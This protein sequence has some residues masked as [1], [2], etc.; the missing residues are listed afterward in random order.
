MPVPPSPIAALRAMASHPIAALREIASHSIAALRD[1]SPP[2]IAVSR[3]HVPSSNA[4][5]HEEVV[6][7]QRV[8]RTVLVLVLLATTAT[9]VPEARAQRVAK[10]GAD[11]LGVG[12]GGRALGM[13]GAYVAA[14]E[15]VTSAYWNPAGLTAMDSLEVAYMHAERFAGVVTFDYA[16]VGT[17]ISDRST[18]GVTVIRSGV[19]DIKNT[20][21]AW[22]PVRGAPR[23]NPSDHITTFSAADYAFM[24]SAGRR[25]G[26]GLAAGATAKIVRRSIGDF[27]S[28]WGYSVDVGARYQRGRW[29]LGASVRDVTTL[30]ESWSVDREATRPLED[31]FDLALPEGG[32]ELVLPVLRTGAA[33]TGSWR[34]FDGT[35]GLDLD[36]AFEGRRAYAFNAGDVSLHPRIGGELAYQNV[37]ALRGGLNRIY[38]AEGEG[39]VLS[40]TV[41]AGLTLGRV[42]V[43]Y[44]FGNFAGLAAEL[45]YSHR[46][47]LRIRLHPPAR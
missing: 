9:V 42:V 38:T 10:Y 21:Q 34:E 19:N 1:V 39:L 23:P 46:L 2:P 43:D 25:L 11:F 3:E 20:L 26:G 36:L 32:T 15:D 12:I 5:A 35:L 47:S 30:L 24:V 28:A 37:V 7:F 31:V 8:V 29:V 17:P 22:D 44:G 4:P 6:E 14:G 40:P 27:A 33:A 18:V 13:G 16:G 41:G 45:G